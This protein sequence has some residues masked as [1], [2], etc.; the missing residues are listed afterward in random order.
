MP[1]KNKTL[2]VDDLGQTDTF[3]LCRAGRQVRQEA[4]PH[5][6]K[7]SDFTVP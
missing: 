3:C 4:F 5:W 7:R 6:G 2:C 1:K